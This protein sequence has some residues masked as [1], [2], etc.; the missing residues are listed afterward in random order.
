MPHSSRNSSCMVLMGEA[1]KHVVLRLQLGRSAET[2]TIM[3]E[4][5]T[6]LSFYGRDL[7][8]TVICKEKDMVKA[9]APTILKCFT[10][11]EAW[12][13]QANQIGF[14]PAI[15]ALLLPTSLETW[16][17]LCYCH[18]KMIPESIPVY[19]VYN[20]RYQNINYTIYIG[21]ITRQT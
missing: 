11:F 21:F 16:I 7:G 5:V 10:D 20:F 18:L 15:K 8:W 13:S 19:T 17:V 2:D 4:L 12:K 14:V 3:Q 6:I 1:R 9:H